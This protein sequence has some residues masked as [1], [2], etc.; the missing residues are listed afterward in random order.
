MGEIDL[1]FYVEMKFYLSRE[2]G[3]LPIL[4][5]IR[6]WE[7]GGLFAVKQVIQGAGGAAESAGMVYAKADQVVHDVIRV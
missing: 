5:P 3:P 4:D 7:G 2:W 1:L 6:G